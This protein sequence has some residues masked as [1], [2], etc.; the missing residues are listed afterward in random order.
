MANE[1]AERQA[2]YAGPR[3]TAVKILNRIERTDSYLDKLLDVELKSGELSDLDKNLLAEIVHGVMR[4]QGRLDWVLNGFTHG[5]FSK[6]EVNIKN[7][8]RVALYQLLF[9]T[10]V[11]HYAAVNEAVE[12]IKRIR[13]EK[14]GHLV[15]AVLRNIIRSLD[16]IHYPKPE[17]DLAQYLAVYYSHPLWMVKRWMTRFDREELE[18]FLAVNN[19]VPNL[20]LRINKLKIPPA[21]FL[22]MLDNAK[23]TYQGSSF[24]DYFIKLKSL[25]GIGQMKMFQSGYFSIQDESAALAV[26]LLDPHP[27]D[28][29]I[30]MCAAPGGKTTFIAELMNNRGEVL[31]V[32]KYESRL[33]IIKINCDRLGIQN[34]RLHVADASEIDTPPADR[35]LI[36]V[37]CSGLGVLRKKPD[38]KWKREPEDIQRLARQQMNL[39][40]RGAQLVKPGGVLVYS[41]CTTEPEENGMQIRSFLER[42]PDFALDDASRFVNKA[43]VNADGSIETFPHRHHIDGTFAARLVRSAVAAAGTNHQEEQAAQ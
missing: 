28:R 42:H 10:H 31:A 13:G 22:S 18:R 2:L 32:D 41:T 37:P 4:W 26:L 36:D 8:G 23:I 1:T 40:E 19:E 29:V 34:V 17:E 12:F 16:A 33:R 11:P 6:S 25:S 15:N 35:V 27:G 43:A 30:D 21:E 3:G 5:N 24:I 38:I 9:L 39:L 20:T 7:T 14:S